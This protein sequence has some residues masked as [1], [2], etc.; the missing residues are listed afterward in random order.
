MTAPTVERRAPP[1]GPDLLAERLVATYRELD[2]LARTD[3]LEPGEPAN[4]AF[5]ELVGLCD[6]R[7]G[8]VATAV[9]EDP[10]VAAIAGRLRRLCSAGEYRLERSWAGR[11]ATADDADLELRSFPYLANYRAL[12]ALEMGTV[13]GLLA[14]PPGRACVLGSGPLPLTA[15]LL[16]GRMNCAVDAVDLEP[17]ATALARDVLRRLTGGGLVRPWQADAAAFDGEAEADIVLLAALVGLDPLAK[18]TVISAVVDRMRPGA[19]LLVRTAYRLRTLLYPL[20]TA[21]DLIAA[22]G[23]RLRP[24]AQVHPF[25]DVVNSFVVAART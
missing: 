15:L 6:H 3:G 9:L 20:L 12:V 7:P 24:L 16:A 5:T 18:R 1:P 4:R 22:G 14:G 2:S 13:T 10:R 21:D 23:G 25:G 19:L 8:P 11:I 17:E